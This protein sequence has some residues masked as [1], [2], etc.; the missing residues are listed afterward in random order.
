MLKGIRDAG[1]EDLQ[2]GFRRVRT[3]GLELQPRTA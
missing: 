2:F 3:G 1:F